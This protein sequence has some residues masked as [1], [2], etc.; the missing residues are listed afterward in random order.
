MM[1]EQKK[2]NQGDLFKEIYTEKVSSRNPFNEGSG[3]VTHKLS[4]ESFL[5]FVLFTL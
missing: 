3:L 2:N 5:F 1:D 4:F